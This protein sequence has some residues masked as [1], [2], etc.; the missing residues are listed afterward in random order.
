MS[1]SFDIFEFVSCSS[2][3]GRLA[4]ER[5][6]WTC[7]A[8]QKV[9]P[10]IDGIPWLYENAAAAISEWQASIG[11]HLQQLSNNA[12]AIKEELKLTN[13]LES[14]RRR[15]LRQLQA[16]VEQRKS[17]ETLLAGV[18]STELDPQV[19]LTLSET[20]RHKAPKTQSLTGYY[21]NIHRDWAWD[22]GFSKDENENQLSFDLIAPFFDADL[23]GKTIA[24]LGGGACRLP[25]DIHRNLH[26]MHTVVIDINPL[27][28]YAAKRVIQGQA[29]PLYEF[30][31]APRDIES[32]AVARR[33]KAP[34]PIKKGMSF[35]LADAMAP[36]FQ[37]ASVDVVCTPWFIDI[38]P[39]D[40]RTLL[41]RIAAMLKPGGIWVNFGSLVFNHSEFHRRY[42]QEEVFEIAEQSGFV[43]ERHASK[44]LPYMQSPASHHSRR[45]DVQ[46]F[47][48]SRRQDFV[49]ASICD[50]S[51]SH[52][53]EWLLDTTTP[54]PRDQAIETFQITHAAYADVAAL[55]D[56]QRPI[57]QIAQVF[58]QKHGMHVDEIKHALVRFLANVYEQSKQ[59]P[60]VFR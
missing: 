17:I 11:L 36:P 2:C 44:V 30:P 6:K 34:E 4:A 9:F 19:L 57:E 55:I 38:V 37:R 40:L 58:S 27:L 41:P 46:V 7:L 42:S 10:V 16:F 49:S 53:P 3:A 32:Y 29:V 18:R 1:Q 15:L 54:V 14:T 22:D 12:A 35:V 33:C 20:M 43:I 50:T 51:Y 47:A 48:A 24:V 8:C 31:L 5:L 56:G 26:P 59:G 21:T 25:Y 45:E 28:L 13:I 52:L 23:S 39:Q 60:L